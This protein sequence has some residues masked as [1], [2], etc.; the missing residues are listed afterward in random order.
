MKNYYIQETL[1][2]KKV[3]TKQPLDQFAATK[4]WEKLNKSFPGK[5]Q[6]VDEEENENR[7]D[8][9]KPKIGFEEQLF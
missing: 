1:T 2:K 9:R 8:V 5:Y 4:L 7:N 3:V 6:I